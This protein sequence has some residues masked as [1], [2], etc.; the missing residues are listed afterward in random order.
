MCFIFLVI[1]ALC[2]GII[3]VIIPAIYNHY[4]MRQKLKRFP[5][6]PGFPFIK[7]FL[8]VTKLSEHG[9]ELYE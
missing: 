2:V 3:F 7:S 6:V 4:I 9:K 8:E 5:Q 1:S